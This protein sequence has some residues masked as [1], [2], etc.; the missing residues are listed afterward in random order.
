M[1]S[2]EATFNFGNLPR[3]MNPLFMLSRSLPLVVGW[4]EA[5]EMYIE[6]PTIT[7]QKAWQVGVVDSVG[8]FVDET[9][10]IARIKVSHLSPSSHKT[11]D[12]QFN[13]ISDT[14][15]SAQEVLRML[16]SFAN[17]AALKPMKQL[18]LP[19]KM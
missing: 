5:M 16:E 2:R 1:S 18:D 10:N 14:A 9:K 3:G 6:D 17:R 13:C 4:S 7:A 11:K 8:D 19:K 12:G 15:H